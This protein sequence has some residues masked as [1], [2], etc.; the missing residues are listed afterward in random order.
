MS[1]QIIVNSQYNIGHICTARQ[2][3]L[4]RSDKVAMRWI[5]ASHDRTDYTFSDL[6]RLSNQFAHVLQKLGFSDGDIVFT[7]LP[8]MPEQFV[9]FLGILKLKAIAGTLFAN[10]GEEALLDRLGDSRASC[11]VTKKSFVRKITNIRGELPE[12]E[13]ISSSSTATSTWPPIS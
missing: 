3:E 12:S 10:F 7:F 2:C 4:G 1:E 6:D 9:S 5:G 8:K 11:I 13:V